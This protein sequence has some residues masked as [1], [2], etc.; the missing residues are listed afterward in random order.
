VLNSSPQA[1]AFAAYKKAATETARPER[2]LIMLFDGG[3]KFLFQAQSALAEKDYEK[4]NNLMIKVQ[5]IL[6]TLMDTLNFEQGGDIAKNLYSLYSFYRREVMQAN[7]EKNGERL[8]PVL[9][10]FQSYRETWAKAALKAM[11]EKDK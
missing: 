9:K 7:I 1:G 4:A 3:I 10:F 6:W 2:L 8:I 5:E 11:A